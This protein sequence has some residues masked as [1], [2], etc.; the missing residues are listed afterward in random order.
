MVSIND[1]DAEQYGKILIEKLFGGSLCLRTHGIVIHG[2]IA[3]DIRK[4]LVNNYFIVILLQCLCNLNQQ[5]Q[6][7]HRPLLNHIK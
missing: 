1:V 6:H 7:Q 2:Y 3:Q 5:R 4:V